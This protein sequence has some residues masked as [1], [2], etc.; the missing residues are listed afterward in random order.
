MSLRR[1]ALVLA[2]LTLLALWPG[3]PRRAAADADDPDGHAA[4]AT[5]HIIAHEYDEARAEPDRG[6]P[7]RLAIVLAKARL[8]IYE[9]ECDLAVATLGRAD[10]AKDDDGRALAEIARGCARV[11]AATVV[12]RRDAE[13][14]V[15]RYQDD[16]DRA[17]T[18]LLA[19]TAAAA[20][21]QL[22]ADLGVEWR[23]PTR[24]T[25]VRD[26]LSLSAMTGL[27][28]KA[29]QTTGTVAVAKWGRVTI[30]SPR[31]STHGYAY[32]DTLA[33]E[34]T[35]LAISQ[36]SREGAPLWLHE[37]LAKREEVRW[38]PPGPFDAKPDP[39]AIVARGRELHL[40]IPL[41]KLGPS[42][43]MLPSADAAMVAFAEVTSFVRLLAETSGPDVIGKLLVALRTAPSAGEALRAVTGQDLTGWDAKWRADLAKKPSAPLP[44]LFGLGPPPQGMADARDRHRLAELL[45]GRSHA[46]EAL[47][48]LAKVPRDHFLDP[49]L[50]YVEAR[51][52]EAAGAPAEAAAAIGEPTEWLTGFGPCW[53]VQ[54][55]LSVASDPKKSAS[56][57][58]E[59]RAHAPFSFEAACESRP[60][61]PPTTRSALCEA[62]TARD[63]P[64]VGR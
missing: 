18:P 40:D 63:E 17:L 60:G 12:E 36:H 55:R 44:A 38:R 57:F 30:L 64:D 54:G 15:I 19:E 42:I 50:R 5:A 2:G 14:V 48:E 33:H 61:T 59:A 58:A 22:T 51:A 3:A 4:K 37:G 16:A 10:A 45:V 52:H 46:K 39:D 8:A 7:D 47:L 62:A 56:A 28:Y 24:I 29:A 43:A 26:L 35:H 53:A 32:L 49:S 11:T 25:V 9:E 31:A 21:K 34:L 41:D 13:Q 6:D 1:N 23:G 27:P 20:R